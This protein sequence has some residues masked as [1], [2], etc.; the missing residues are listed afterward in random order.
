MSDFRT[1][2]S[3]E[4]RQ[5]L[6]VGNV[7]KR[8]SSGEY[9]V[10]EDRVSI[11]EPLEIHIGDQPLAVTMRTPGHDPELAAGFLFTEGLVSAPGEIEI[12][13]PVAT[14]PNRIR[15]RLGPEK[16]TPPPQLQRYGTI[17]ASCGICGATS[18]QDVFKRH[19]PLDPGDG[20][21]VPEN[22]ILHLPHRMRAAQ[23]QFE[24]SGGLHAS[25]LFGPDGTL[26]CLRED[27]GR[28]NALDKVAGWALLGGLLPLHNHLL[29]VS[30][31]TSFE[32]VQKTLALRI[33]LVAGISAPSSLAV[34][35]ARDA[36]ITLLGFLRDDRFNCYT[37]P[38]RL[39]R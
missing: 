25:A 19:A 35:F 29:L 22:T 39:D 26:R 31:R 12:L 16:E 9:R 23:A 21:K 2:P 27:I 14:H 4:N 20:L 1:G 3:A 24:H 33:P 28:H 6:A 38:Q 36:G 13:P 32:L 8:S 37:H 7:L 17:Q 15:L 34:N 10:E 5:G 30:G 11:E 18:I